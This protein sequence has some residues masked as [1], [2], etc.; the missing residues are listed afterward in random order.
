MLF[1][2]DNRIYLHMAILERKIVHGVESSFSHIVYPRFVLPRHRHAE[3][4][5]MVVTSGSGKQFVGEGVAEYEAGDMALIGSSVPHLHLCNATLNGE[6]D[7][8][9]AG[10]ALQFPPSLFPIN[11]E[12]LPDFSRIAR[13]LRKSRYGIRFRDPVLSA[14]VLNL[15]QEIDR[16][17]GIERVIRLFRILDTLEQSSEYAL[18]SGG[19]YNAENRI[20]EGADPASRVYTYLFNHFREPVELAAVAAYTGMNPTALC[21]A[22]RQR[23][24]KSIFRCLAE[25]RVEHACKLLTHSKLTVSQV[26]YESGY[27]NL[28]HFN[29]QFMGIMRRTPTDYRSQINA[30]F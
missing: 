11:M 19:E 20:G 15:M 13:L 18:L 8:P 5:L 2:P 3:F 29:R 30:A 21:R 28:S 27:N 7:N 6:T 16:L 1:L 23:T 26:A 4:E 12:D 24:D 25:I 17:S 22:F 14:R 9:S 10:E